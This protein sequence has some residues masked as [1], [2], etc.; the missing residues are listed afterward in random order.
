MVLAGVAA[1]Q[2]G[3]GRH[4]QVPLLPGR[5]LP[6]GAVGH[7]RGEHGLPLPVG[8]LQGAVAA[9]AVLVPDGLP[10]ALRSLRLDSLRLL[11]PSVVIGGADRGRQGRKPES[12][13]RDPQVASLAGRNC[14]RARRAAAGLACFQPAVVGVGAGDVAAGDV[15]RAGA[16]ASGLSSASAVVVTGPAELPFSQA[17][18]DSCQ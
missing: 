11:S 1:A 3:V 14:P 2:F 12:A 5:G 17:D 6:F 7:D 16:V 4:G 18:Q 10:L 13:I 9:G 15:G 8:L